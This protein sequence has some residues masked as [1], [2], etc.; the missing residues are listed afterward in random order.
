MLRSRS[1]RIFS[2]LNSSIKYS[3]RKLAKK[4]GV[5]KSAADRHKKPIEKRNR[6]LESYFWEIEEGGAFL[7]RL[8]VGVLFL[9][10]IK[11]GIGAGTICEFFKLLHIDKHVGSCTTTIKNHINKIQEMLEEYLKS[12]Q[13]KPVSAKSLKIVGGADETFFNEMILV[14]MELR[15]GFIFV[16]EASEDRCYETWMQKIQNVVDKFGFTFQY[17]VTDRAKALI[18]LAENGLECLSIPDLFHA[19][20]EIVRVFGLRLG[21]KKDAIEKELVKATS[22]LAILKELGKDRNQQ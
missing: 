14:F 19:S 2:I 12:Q 5:S 17:I 8:F 1:Y 18:K 10:G 7:C 3:I 21:R 6:F 9:F 20:H 4:A 16:E 13:A 15:S 22:A 11:N